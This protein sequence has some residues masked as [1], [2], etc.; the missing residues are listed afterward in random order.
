MYG[1]L[2]IV[3]YFFFV[4]IVTYFVSLRVNRR[5]T[6][7]IHFVFVNGEAILA[8]DFMFTIPVENCRRCTLSIKLCHYFSFQS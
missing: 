6:F 1:S 2:H 7:S 5:P 3:T 4:N 8:M